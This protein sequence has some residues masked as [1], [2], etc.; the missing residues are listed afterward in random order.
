MATAARACKVCGK[1]CP[2]CM[3]ARRVAG[4][5]HWQDVACSPEHG[6]IYLARINESRGEN[7]VV[8]AAEAEDIEIDIEAEEDLFEEDF[9]D[10]DEE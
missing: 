4:I 5:F 7:K 8:P 2:Y 3:T 10:E 1:A 9:D 6:S